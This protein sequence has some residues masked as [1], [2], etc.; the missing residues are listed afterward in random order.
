MRVQLLTG[1]QLARELDI[2]SMSVSR[3]VRDRRITPDFIAGEIQLFRPAR[4]G[5]IR[6]AIGLKPAN[7]L[8]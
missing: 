3:A 1:S 4:L 6:M 2:S 5:K 8:P 7:S